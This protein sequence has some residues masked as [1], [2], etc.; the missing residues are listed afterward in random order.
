MGCRWCPWHWPCRCRRRTGVIVGR[1]GMHAASRSHAPHR[2][3]ARSSRAAL[4][5]APMGIALAGNRCDWI[6]AR[7]GIAPTGSCATSTCTPQLVPQ[8][9]TETRTIACIEYRT[10]QRQQKCSVM[11]PVWEDQQQPYVVMVPYQEERKATRCVFDRVTDNV[12]QKYCVMVPYQE[13]HR[14]RG[15]STTR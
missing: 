10:E 6:S 4:E 14:P 15:K 13:R 9:T 1:G 12:E 11:R 8:W 3:A 5:I 2:T 7:P